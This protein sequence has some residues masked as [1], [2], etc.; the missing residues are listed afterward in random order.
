MK[1]GDPISDFATFVPETV[2][3]DE[4]KTGQGAEQ[5]E[6]EGGGLADT[7]EAV[8]LVRENWGQNL[9]AEDGAC[10]EEVG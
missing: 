9:E 10:G 3:E 7:G 4:E 1:C 6:G 5:D 8:A 2:G